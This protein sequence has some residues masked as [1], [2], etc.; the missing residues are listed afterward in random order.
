MNKNVLTHTG[1]GGSRSAGKSA[2][3]GSP[4][5]SVWL[6][7]SAFTMAEILLS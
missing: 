6:A 1:G 3:N 7:L 2:A 5:A 4:Q